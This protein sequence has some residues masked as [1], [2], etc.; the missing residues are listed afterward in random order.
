MSQKISIPV[1]SRRQLSIKKK[2]DHI[3]SA[4]ELIHAPWMCFPEQLAC[5]CG[6]TVRG[7][8]RR[9]QCQSLMLK[10]PYK[11]RMGVKQK[12]DHMSDVHLCI[13]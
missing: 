12:D 1:L 2:I 9:S 13:C 11:H 3:P 4:T 5:V 10:G 8:L 7:S 6:H